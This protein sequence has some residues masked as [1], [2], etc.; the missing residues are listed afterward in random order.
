MDNAAVRVRQWQRCV[1]L[2]A[3]GD[4]VAWNDELV[5]QRY[6]LLYEAGLVAEAGCTP[7]STVP[8]RAMHHDHRR[9]L[10]TGMARL[11]AKIRYR[12]VVF[13]LMPEEFTLLQLQRVMESL[14]G[15]IS[16]NRISAA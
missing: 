7:E 13:E 16:I 5:L 2:F 12:P 4:M 10:A 1:A 9:I 6:E 15:S 3:I 14:S 8:G 11:R